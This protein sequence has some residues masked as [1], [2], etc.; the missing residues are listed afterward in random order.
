M[1]DDAVLSLYL[2]S[3]LEEPA[4]FARA[5]FV[6]KGSG[7]N[8]VLPQVVRVNNRL[9]KSFNMNSGAKYCMLF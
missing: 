5:L 1:S 4:I 9:C 6:D 3:A 8:T 2:H 7:F